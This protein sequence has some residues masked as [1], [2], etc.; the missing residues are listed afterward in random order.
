MSSLGQHDHGYNIIKGTTSP[1]TFSSRV[2]TIDFWKGI[3][4]S[5]H[6]LMNPVYTVSALSDSTHVF[7]LLS[8]MQELLK[9]TVVVQV[10]QS[11]P[12]SAI[13]EEL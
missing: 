6:F 5:D 7:F 1:N 9:L 11:L 3:P 8:N 2:M 10:N 12:I 4:H 13:D